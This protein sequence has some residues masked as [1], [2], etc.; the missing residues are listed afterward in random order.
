[1]YSQL[2]VLCQSMPKLG[3]SGKLKR[4]Y[5]VRLWTRAY[6]CLRELFNAFYVKVGG[7]S[8]KVINLEYLLNYLDARGLAI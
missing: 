2:G 4:Y 7:V 3:W 6:P 8:T 1:M 5:M